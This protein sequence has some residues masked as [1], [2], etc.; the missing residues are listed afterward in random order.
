MTAVRPG[1][2]LFACNLNRVRSPMAEGLVKLLYG[3]GIYADSCG[4][5]PTGDFDPFAVQV[6]RE[7]GVDLSRHHAKSFDDLDP[8]AFDLVVSLTPEAHHRAVA[9]TRNAAVDTIHWPTFDP[10]LARGSREAVLD[11]YRG[12]RDSLMARIVERFGKPSTSGG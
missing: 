3:L 11:A 7:L 2:V 8:S 12:V 6:M 5:K 4:L 10:T 1:A 9:M